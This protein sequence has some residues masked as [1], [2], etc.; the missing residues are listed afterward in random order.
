[1]KIPVE[2][3]RRGLLCA[4]GCTGALRAA[5]QVD[6]TKPRATSGDA[7]EPEWA[8]RLTV[9]VGPRQA[10]LTGSDERVLQAAVNMVKR[11]GGGT[12]RV[13]PGEYRLRNAVRLESGVRILGS[14]ADSVLIKEASF[15]TKISE[16]SD[17]YEQEVT[18]ADAGPLRVGDGVCIRAANPHHSGKTVLKRTLVARSGNRFKLDK[19]LRDNIWLKCEPTLSTLFPILTGEEISDIAIENIA[20]DGNRSNNQNLDG[21]HAGCIFFQDC[22]RI[23][24]RRVIARNYNGDGMS[25]QICHDVTV[26]DCHSHGHSGLGLHPGSGSQR[27]LMRRNVSEDNDIGIFFCW[28]V[29]F[30]VAEGNLLRNNRGSGISIGHRDNDNI[31]RDNEVVGSGK[32]GVLFRRESVAAFHARRTR[33]EGNRILDT[34]GEDGIG[35]D[36]RGETGPAEIVNNQVRERRAPAKR[37]GI[38]ME[39]GVRGIRLEGNTLEGFAVPVLDL[40]G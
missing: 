18:V 19:A 25:W 7:A 1:M 28:G 34:G 31:V 27:S 39:A 37:T 14:G 35:I 12:V 40:R 5:G 6:P 13:L 33:L 20:L 2:M 21:N 11:A 17:W 36:I 22:N 9:T 10:D 4:A 30:S 23:A 16:D 15:T 26:E 3:S 32:V 38:R 8:E 24:I 29:R